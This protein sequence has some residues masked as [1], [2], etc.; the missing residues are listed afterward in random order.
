MAKERIEEFEW[1]GKCEDAGAERVTS[2]VM[3]GVAGRA[4]GWGRPD[5]MAVVR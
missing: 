2:S 5:T 1:V 4:L 3:I